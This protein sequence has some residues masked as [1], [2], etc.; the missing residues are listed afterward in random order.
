ME[1]LKEYIIESDKANNRL[2]KIISVLDDT[3]S[4]TAVKRLIEEIR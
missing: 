2:D 3:I 1:F 4:R